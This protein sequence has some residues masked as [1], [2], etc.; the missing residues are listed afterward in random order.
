MANDNSN[1]FKHFERSEFLLFRK[2]CISLILATDNAK[3][4]MHLDRFKDFIETNNIHD[5]REELAL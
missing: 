1:P 2:M 4:F 5:E 3:H